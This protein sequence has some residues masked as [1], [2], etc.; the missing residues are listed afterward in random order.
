M[1]SKIHTEDMKTLEQYIEEFANLYPK[2]LATTL[3][4][5]ERTLKEYGEAVQEEERKRIVDGLNKNLPS[6]A[7]FMY[8]EYIQEALTPE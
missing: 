6:G 2:D 4:Y 5:L 3:T 8:R 7:K 1:K